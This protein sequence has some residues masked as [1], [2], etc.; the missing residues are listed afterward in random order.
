MI[1]LYK[2]HVPPEVGAALQSAISGGQI[3]NGPKVVEFEKALRHLIGNPFL[4]STANVSSTI[5]M[6]L[7]MAGA[8]PGT[9]VIVSPMS[10]VASTMPVLMTGATMRW[11]DIDPATGNI[12]PESAR[13]QITAKTRALLVNHWVGHP[14]DLAPLATLCREHGIALIDDASEALGATYRGKQLGTTGSDYTVFCFNPIRHLN[15]GEG[16]AVAFV[17][18]ELFRRGEKLKRFGIDQTTFRD[19]LGEIRADSDILEASDQN[20]MS[21]IHAAFGLAQWP[22]LDLLLNRPKENG[23][24][25]SEAIRGLTDFQALTCPPDSE[26][27]YWVFPL[28]AERRD[29]LLVWLRSQGIGASKGHIRNDIYSCYGRSRETLPGVDEFERQQINLPCGW[30]VGETDLN[31]ISKA[32][33]K[34]TE[35]ESA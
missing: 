15:C 6:C 33:E 8:G 28:R 18:E 34:W 17:R 11:C 9:E 16:A 35:H 3:N 22:Y 19:K 29:E 21:Q 30:W 23:K 5:E 10:C 12:C 4:T 7:R 26:P 32:L 25:L 20:F 13:K 24:A 1:P 2:P 27:A 14:A 31:L